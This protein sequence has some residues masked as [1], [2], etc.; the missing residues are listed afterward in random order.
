MSSPF[1]ASVNFQEDNGPGAGAPFGALDVVWR[2][3]ADLAVR[4]VYPAIDPIYSVSSLVESEQLEANHLAVASRARRLLRRYREL[5]P[6]VTQRGLDRY[7]AADRETY[8]RGERLEAFMTQPFFVA[9]PATKR[10]GVSV[11]LPET[12]AGVRRILD[13]EADTAPAEALRWLGQLSDHL[14]GDPR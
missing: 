2:F 5:R 7:P 12:L 1:Q 10:P 6:G 14:W 11:A 4:G 9:E 3:D 13:G 8:E